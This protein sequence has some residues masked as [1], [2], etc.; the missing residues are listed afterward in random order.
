MLNIFEFTDFRAYLKN[1]Y[2]RHKALDAN[3]SYA[4][5]A[6]RTKLSSRGLLKLIMDGKRNLSASNLHNMTSGLG[7]NK[8][9][10]HY[11]S[12]LVQFAQAKTAEEKDK[13]YSAI[14]KFPQ[15]K[16]AFALK[17][18]QHNFYSKWYFAVVLELVTLSTAPT[19]AAELARWISK[20][21]DI[22][23]KEAADA[24]EQLQ[25]L[26]LLRA[27]SDGRLVQSNPYVAFNPGELHFALQN[28]HRHMIEESV[29]ALKQPIDEREFGGVTL[30]FRKEDLAK[31]KDFIREFKK[32]FNF[33]MS[34]GEGAN[35][36]YQLNVQFF[37]LADGHSPAETKASS[38][39]ANEDQGAAVETPIPTPKIS[40]EIL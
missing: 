31:A 20:K 33:E 2:E 5:M 8:S 22:T 9:E 24:C 36:V 6:E 14:L 37:E 3:F 30:A 15:T 12:T 23:P 32:K 39:S 16:K 29:E 10:T 4:S 38:N 17:Q 40:E 1:Y 7:F 27:G 13:H 28:F 25:T 11:F 18:E 34:A 26:G 19:D 21:I 35:S